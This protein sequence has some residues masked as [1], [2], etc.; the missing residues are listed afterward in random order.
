MNMPVL[1]LLGIG[2][3]CGITALVSKH[4]PSQKYDINM[5]EQEKTKRVFENNQKRIDKIMRKYR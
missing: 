2:T 4:K 1:I 5:S 3:V